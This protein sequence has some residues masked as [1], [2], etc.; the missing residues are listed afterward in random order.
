MENFKVAVYH[1]PLQPASYVQYQ[2]MNVH[3]CIYCFPASG[4]SHSKTTNACWVMCVV[5]MYECIYMHM[6][7]SGLWL[8]RINHNQRVLDHVGSIYVWMYIY[9]YDTFWPPGLS[10]STTINACWVM[11][12]V[13]MYVEDV[14]GRDWGVVGPRSTAPVSRHDWDILINV[15]I[16]K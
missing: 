16:D 8:I 3:T 4:L 15:R 7:P 2:C 14:S 11:C 1:V 13:S 9:L 12:V 6:L 10:E 5:S